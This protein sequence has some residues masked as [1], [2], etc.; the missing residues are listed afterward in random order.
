MFHETI[1]LSP[2]HSYVYRSIRDEL[3][4]FKHSCVS[5]VNR[6]PTG[7]FIQDGK[8]FS[9]KREGSQI[10]GAMPDRDQICRVRRDWALQ[11]EP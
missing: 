1:W 3:L 8:R 7:T 5:A 11:Q 6:M 9:V 2:V 4:R 10:F